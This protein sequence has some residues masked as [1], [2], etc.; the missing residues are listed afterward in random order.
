MD[1][2]EQ[3]RQHAEERERGGEP[4]LKGTFVS[5]M[6]LGAFLIASWVA[7][8]VLFATRQ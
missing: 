4:A 1:K 8:F 2:R 5:V 7:V 6:L 3:K